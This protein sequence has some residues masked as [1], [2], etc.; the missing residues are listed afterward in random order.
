MSVPRGI[1]GTGGCG[2][3]VMPLAR[4]QFPGDRLVF[5]EDSP[6]EQTCNG[7]HVMALADFAAVPGA[8]VA[9][10]KLADKVDITNDK[11]SAIS[12]VLGNLGTAT[13]R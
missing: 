9:A 6:R 2:R 13:F 8:V 11:L 4:D 3:G 5:V 7:M 10:E 1:F 12:S